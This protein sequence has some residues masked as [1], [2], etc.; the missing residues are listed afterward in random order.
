MHWGQVSCWQEEGSWA[1]Q[2]GHAQGHWEPGATACAR[3]SPCSGP[4]SGGAA[5]VTTQ[6]GT[7]RALEVW[8]VQTEV[9][10]KCQ[11]HRCQRLGK[12][13]MQS[14]I[15]VSCVLPLSLALAS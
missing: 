7:R 6:P 9:C 3:S 13:K 1:L 2:G 14:F 12:R 8:P 11:T 10:S 4:G 5:V 15:T